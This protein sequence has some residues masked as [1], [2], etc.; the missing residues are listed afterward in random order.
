MLDFLN[1][2]QWLGEKH[3]DQE[4][5][6]NVLIDT[7]N[8]VKDE[9][10]GDKIVNVERVGR[11]IAPLHLSTKMWGIF[12]DLSMD[13]S[14]RYFKGKTPSAMRD[15]WTIVNVFTSVA[16]A[17]KPTSHIPGFKQKRIGKEAVQKRMNRRFKQISNITGQLNKV[18]D[19]SDR[20]AP[21][22]FA[23]KQIIERLE[24]N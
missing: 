17:L 7:A 1:T 20:G 24:E 6:V 10:F 14:K 19:L 8:V 15:H 23:A 21:R 13:E 18:R 4:Y 22:E 9:T 16:D 12:G 2:R 11:M 5:I 3:L